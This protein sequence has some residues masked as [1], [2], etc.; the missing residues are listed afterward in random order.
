[1]L[2]IANKI[3][4]NFLPQNKI[5]HLKKCLHKISLVVNN[6]KRDI[7]SETKGDRR[8]VRSYME[9]IS[10]IPGGK[11]YIMQEVKP[12][13]TCIIKYR[14]LTNDG[15]DTNYLE[16]ETS[17]TVNKMMRGCAVCIH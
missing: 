13:F 9:I 17:S 8:K 5:P 6:K 14:G 7:F 4:Q 2:Q 1:M 15:V 12:L 16:M 11:T 10:K 3:K